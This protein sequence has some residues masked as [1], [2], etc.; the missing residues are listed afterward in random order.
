MEAKT[1]TNFY[2]FLGIKGLQ[3]LRP[4]DSI[5]PHDLC[6]WLGAPWEQPLGDGEVTVSWHV[7]SS[8]PHCDSINDRLPLIF[9][10]DHPVFFYFTT[11]FKTC[12]LYLRESL[13]DLRGDKSP[14]FHH[15]NS[16]QVVHVLQTITSQIGSV[17]GGKYSTNYLSETK[18]YGYQFLLKFPS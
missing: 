2:Q 16:R 11:F 4:D 14:S 10:C 9:C 13:Q 7:T 6:K 5:W 12:L 18:W 17:E 3:L 15:L 8:S 1:P